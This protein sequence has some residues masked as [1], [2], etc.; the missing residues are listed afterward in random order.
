[1]HPVVPRSA[2]TMPPYH[3]DLLDFYKLQADCS[4]N[5]VIHTSYVKDRAKSVQRVRVEQ[6]WDN[7]KRIGHGTFGEVWLQKGDK[8]A[9]RA[10][11]KISKYRMEDLDIDYKRELDALAKFNTP[12]VSSR[13]HNTPVRYPMGSVRIMMPGLLAH[14]TISFIVVDN[15]DSADD[16][17]DKARRGDS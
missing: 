9:E 11:K 4:E 16:L 1:M 10:V 6:R 5:H 7:V 8:G 17:Q 2:L 15:C 13:H 14:M 12:R 3:S